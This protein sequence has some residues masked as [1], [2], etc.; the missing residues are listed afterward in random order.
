[1]NYAHKDKQYEYEI[2]TKK[3]DPPIGDVL[4]HYAKIPYCYVKDT[5]GRRKVEHN[6]GE[7]HGKSPEEAVKRMKKLLIQW[8]K[9]EQLRG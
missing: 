1:M 7:T 6:F 9:K 4:T 5:K 2:D 3:L 8:V